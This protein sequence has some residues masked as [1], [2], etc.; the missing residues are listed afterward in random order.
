[1]D[2]DYNN[3]NVDY[4]STGNIEL[5][6]GDK[7]IN[8]IMYNDDIYMKDEDFYYN[9]NLTDRINYSLSTPIVHGKWI[10]DDDNKIISINNNIPYATVLFEIDQNK[11]TVI[12]YT[13]TSA[14][15][16]YNIFV[17]IQNEPTRVG[18]YHD[19]T[20]AN[21]NGGISQTFIH[22]NGTSRSNY[23]TCL[24]FCKLSSTL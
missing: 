3:Y 19:G 16:N 17:G 10:W 15:S 21:G 14:S 20:S 22:D 9:I 18:S 23:P 4:V 1:M 6:S 7:L 13:K 8:H 12:N 5:Y 2:N 11:K 24:V